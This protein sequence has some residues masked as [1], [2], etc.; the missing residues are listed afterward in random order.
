VS[1]VRGDVRGFLEGFDKGRVN[2][3]RDVMRLLMI[4]LADNL[5]WFIPAIGILIRKM[6]KNVS[7][8]ESKR[9]VWR[10]VR[11]DVWF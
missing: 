2:V 9:V 3:D 4:W 11:W 6:G 7:R 1:R 5:A 10:D 8:V